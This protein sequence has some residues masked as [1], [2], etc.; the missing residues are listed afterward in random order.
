MP[1]I[2]SVKEFSF[3]YTQHRF[4]GQATDEK[5]LYVERENP[6]MLWWKRGMVV[7]FG[8]FIFLAGSWFASLLESG[9]GVQVPTIVPMIFLLIGLGVILI[10]WWWVTALWKKSIGLI[11][12]KRLT[13]FIYTT[14]INRHN[15][16]LPLDMI[17]DTGAYSK[18]F[19]QAIFG[20]ETFTARSSAASSGVATDNVDRVNKK[21]FYL[22]N[23]KM[24]ED[25]QHYVNK[26]L[27]AYRHHQEHLGT[28]RPFISK[29]SGNRDQLMEQHPDY[30]S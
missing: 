1:D 14:P 15:L 11:T 19:I 23:I 4:P 24:A 6:I 13:K 20:L 29:T 2:F 17:V 30:W 28:F 10:G 25:L 16:S 27:Y 7:I 5:I 9:L 26:L 21:Y 3:P 22:E 8:L 12:T 18:G